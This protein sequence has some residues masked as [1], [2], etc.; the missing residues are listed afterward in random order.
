MHNVSR[1]KGIIKLL[2][3]TV[4]WNSTNIN[5]VQ[6]AKLNTSNCLRWRRC[7]LILTADAL[8]FP[9][10]FSTFP[11]IFM[12]TTP[13][14]K[15]ERSTS[16]TEWSLNSQLSFFFRK[17]DLKLKKITAAFSLTAWH[18]HPVRQSAGWPPNSQTGVR[19]KHCSEAVCRLAGPHT[20]L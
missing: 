6:R 17:S 12:S 13:P 4:I 2:S 8:Y 19:Q 7:H 5:N 20:E 3:A 9:S 18:P 15:Q 14:W 10:P 1:V 11:S 16:C